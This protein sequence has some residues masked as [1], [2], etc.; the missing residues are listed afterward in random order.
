M[1]ANS[2]MTGCRLGKDLWILH[3]RRQIS[4]AET[5]FSIALLSIALR[6][7]SGLAVS[8]EMLRI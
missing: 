3:R 8:E 1:Y 7:A 4:M 5:D 6:E 2:C